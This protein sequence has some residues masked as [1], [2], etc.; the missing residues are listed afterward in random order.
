MRRTSDKDL[1]RWI[2]QR[3]KRDNEGLCTII[4]LKIIC[5]IIGRRDS[6]SM[7]IYFDSILLCNIKSLIQNHT[8]QYEFAYLIFV[9]IVMMETM[10]A[11][12]MEN[13]VWLF[14]RLREIKKD[15]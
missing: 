11:I 8:I 1:E 13:M 12:W 4:T 7:C 14:C 5:A 6:D 9:A 3:E 2:G 15:F 10:T